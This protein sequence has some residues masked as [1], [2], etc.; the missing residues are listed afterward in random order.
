MEKRCNTDGSRGD[1]VCSL[2]DLVARSLSTHPTGVFH[3]LGLAPSCEAAGSSSAS[4]LSPTSLCE[5]PEDAPIVVRSNGVPSFAPA[6]LFRQRP[7][8]EVARLKPGLSP[9][10]SELFLCIDPETELGERTASFPELE[11]ANEPSGPV[12]H[13]LVF[14]PRL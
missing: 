10:R 12:G 9:R 8:D 14:E 3:L 4:V 13:I 11:L 7:I 2:L 1:G 6:G 5:Q